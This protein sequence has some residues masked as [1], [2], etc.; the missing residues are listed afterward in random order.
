MLYLISPSK[1]FLRL[2][3]LSM[4]LGLAACHDSNSSS[5]SA[6]TPPAKPLTGTLTVTP[7][8]GKISNADVILK[9]INGNKVIGTLNT[10]SSGK[11]TFSNIASDIGNVEVE[12]K[13]TTTSMYFDE[14]TEKNVPFIGS[15][16]AAIP[17]TSNAT[18][19]VTP[20]TEA[21]YQ[22]AKKQ[23][24]QLS[25]Q[26]INNAN[27]DISKLFGVEDITKPVT[28]VSNSNDLKQL[29]SNQADS[30]ALLLAAIAESAQTILGT[31]ENSP[32]LKASLALAADATDGKIDGKTATGVSA[33]SLFPYATTNYAQ[34][35]NTHI[36]RLITELQ[37]PAELAQL[38]KLPETVS[39]VEPPVTP[40]VEPPVQ[41]PVTTISATGTITTAN[42]AS[43]GF[44][45]DADGFEISVS[46]KEIEYRFIKRT[47]SGNII[48][49]SELI[50]KANPQGQVV[51]VN[52]SDFKNLGTT[53]LVCYA[54]KPCKG[55][56]ISSSADSKS[57]SI[58]FNDTKLFKLVGGDNAGSLKGT[59]T[60]QISNA[61]AWSVADLPRST[62]GILNVNGINE[63]VISSS[64]GVSNTLISPNTIYTVTT[65]ELNTK[66]GRYTITRTPTASPL[67][68]NTNS[69]VTGLDAIYNCENC[70]TALS[71]S[72]QGEFQQIKFDHVFLKN[73]GTKPSL[74]IKN[75]VVVGSTKGIL[76]S[77][78]EGDFEPLSSSVK[79]RNDEIQYH[80]ST[81]GTIKQDGLS[82]VNIT[83][84]GNTLVTATATAGISGK[85]FICYE[86][87]EPVSG[88]IAC[89]NTVSL[90]ANKRT[91]I[92][93]GLTLK[94]GA[95]GEKKELTLNGTLTNKGI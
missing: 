50:I 34:S 18:V 42:T 58:T 8:L 75:T 95:I 74:T 35:I 41:P 25:S 44:T 51:S 55:I 49:T 46:D 81:V 23:N 68:Y 84:R 57:V 65:T 73:L 21:A 37:L 27:Q 63:P 17:F 39:P 56:S 26:L 38:L 77:S 30:Y 62:D 24:A 12:V 88:A 4:C 10:G 67:T 40:P 92:F 31:E 94:G 6:V 87:S 13:S 11:V 52:Y 78:R 7:S 72:Q 53:P 80:F 2:S 20:L 61:A 60:G 79:S 93:K 71:F 47:L 45:P 48:Y 76:T 33:P 70:P 9:Q 36:G 28:L 69:G 89:G 3:A 82:M 16:H 83:M 32:A 90:G 91:L 66:S 19:A 54:L 22:Y 15:L 1:V 29:K 59:L 43:P 85:V 5:D 86:K 14:A 64:V